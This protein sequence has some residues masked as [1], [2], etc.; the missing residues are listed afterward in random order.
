MSILF[1]ALA[2]AAPVNP[3][4]DEPRDNHELTCSVDVQALDAEGRPRSARRVSAGVA[5][6]V[7]FRGRV[8]PRDEEAP[9][10]F[11]TSSTR[12][13]SAI[14]CWSRRPA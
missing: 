1:L 7:V 12:V 8:S 3:V 13:V 4:S 2:L 6:A 10:L 5:P 14:R 9:T 11:S